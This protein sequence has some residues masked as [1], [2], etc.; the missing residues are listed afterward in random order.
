MHLRLSVPLAV[1][2]NQYKFVIGLYG[3]N[4]MIIM[5]NDRNDPLNQT[6]SNDRSSI[7]T[8]KRKKIEVDACTVADTSVTD[9]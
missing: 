5:S 4:K 2:I 6:R 9:R 3:I 7:E 8:S 1:D